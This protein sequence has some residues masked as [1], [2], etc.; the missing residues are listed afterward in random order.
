MPLTQTTETR[1]AELKAQARRLSAALAEDGVAVSHSRALE[2]IAR[3]Q[4][5]RDWN[6]LSAQVKN[7]PDTTDLAVGQRVRGA[8]L[9]HPFEG[10]IRG[11]R[12]IGSAGHRE[13]IVAFD[14]PIDVVASKD[15]S[16]HRRQVTCVLDN[17]NRSPRKTSDGA[18]ILVLD[19]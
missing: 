2:L 16:S 18:P 19:R 14:R 15:L 4:G 17:A 6:T 5:A 13:V 12:R 10:R 1:L 11:L 7:E 9:G 8:Y 3:Q